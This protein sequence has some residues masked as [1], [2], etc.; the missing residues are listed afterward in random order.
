MYKVFTLKGLK[1]FIFQVFISRVLLCDAVVFGSNVLLTLVPLSPLF[2]SG[3]H[4][5]VFVFQL[6]WYSHQMFLYS[7]H[8]ITPLDVNSSHLVIYIY[9][10]I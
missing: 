7:S 1:G 8:N 5:G 2:N 3:F 9:I 4:L 10:Y 6:L